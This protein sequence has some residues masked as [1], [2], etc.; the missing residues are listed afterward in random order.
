M[1]PL[2]ASVG[3]RIALLTG[4]D[5]AARRASLAA[6]ADGAIDIAVGTR[7][8]SGVTFTDLGLAVVDEQHQFGV[9]SAAAR[10]QA[11]RRSPWS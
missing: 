5:K 4:R 6:L 2:A 7:A 8:V 1:A 11:R 10:F 3:L 9:A